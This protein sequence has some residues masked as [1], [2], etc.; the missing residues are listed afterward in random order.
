MSFVYHL[1][2]EFLWGKMDGEQSEDPDVPWFLEKQRIAN[3]EFEDFVFF[4]F[5][6]CWM[7]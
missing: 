5:K 3:V 1:L 4:S 2:E 7:T 6:F